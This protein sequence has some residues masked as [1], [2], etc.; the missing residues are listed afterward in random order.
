LTFEYGYMSPAEFTVK[1]DLE[2]LLKHKLTRS[3]NGGDWYDPATQT[4]IEVKQITRTKQELAGEVRLN[5]KSMLKHA[6]T[7]RNT[8]V[9]LKLSDGLMLFSNPKTILENSRPDG[10]NLSSDRATLISPLSIFSSSVSSLM[11]L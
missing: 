10:F 6:G 4:E 9:V 7:G 2:K 11:S 5:A 1:R 3:T 8:L